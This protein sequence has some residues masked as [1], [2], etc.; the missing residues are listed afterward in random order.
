MSSELCQ[1]LSVHQCQS[2]NSICKKG[3][4][5]GYFMESDLQHHSMS[6]LCP[7]SSFSCS[8]ALSNATVHH[9]Q[10][11]CKQWQLGLNV[12]PPLVT[13]L[14]S[15]VNTLETA[16]CSKFIICTNSQRPLQA[17]QKHLT[18]TCEFSEFTT[19]FCCSCYSNN[20]LLM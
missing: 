10:S 12:L 17:L 19:S 5:S 1:L 3:E 7:L 4:S 18:D 6:K 2:K 14:S 20:P 16:F 13:P 11:F 8:L 15:P 9:A